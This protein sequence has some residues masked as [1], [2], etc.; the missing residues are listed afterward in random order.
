MLWDAFRNTERSAPV[1]LDVGMRHIHTTRLE[2]FRLQLPLLCPWRQLGVWS[3]R[4]LTRPQQTF[5]ECPH[6]TKIA[7][8]V[9]P[10]CRTA[11]LTFA[12]TGFPKCV[13]P[14]FLGFVPPTTFV[15]SSCQCVVGILL[16]LLNT[17]F[18]CLLRMETKSIQHSCAR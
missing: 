1:W 18:D 4:E 10:V 6:G 2:V 14:A 9:A 16:R 5:G 11:S 13:S 7:E 8:A 12:K 17:I 3:G 15:P